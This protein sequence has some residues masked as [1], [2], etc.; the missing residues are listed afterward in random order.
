MKQN[1]LTMG[2]RRQLGRQ[3]EATI[4]I[5]SPIMKR[6]VKRDYCLQIFGYTGCTE[7]LSPT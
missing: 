6:S 7:I 1:F 3:C 5:A 2:E 4:W